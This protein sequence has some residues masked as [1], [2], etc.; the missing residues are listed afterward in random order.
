[1]IYGKKFWVPML[2][3]KVSGLPG[4]IGAREGSMLMMMSGMGFPLI[5]SL[6]VIIMFRAFS[7]IALTALGLIVS[8]DILVPLLKRKS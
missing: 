8:A 6:N 2:I 7:I 1:M 3:G 4:G 5:E